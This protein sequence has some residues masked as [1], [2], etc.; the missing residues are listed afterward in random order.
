MALSSCHVDLLQ[1]PCNNGICSQAVIY[2]TAV[3]D[4]MQ[5]GDRITRIAVE[6]ISSENFLWNGYV[7]ES[8]QVENLHVKLCKLA[9]NVADVNEASISVVT[10]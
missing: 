9:R 4:F 5:D 3:T 6:P 7:P 10:C 8:T 2:F 1:K